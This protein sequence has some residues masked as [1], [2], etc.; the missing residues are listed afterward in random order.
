MIGRKQLPSALLGIALEGT[1]VHVVQVRRAAESIE[2]QNSFSFDL[3]GNPTT[4]DPAVIGQEIRTALEQKNIKEHRCVIT[5]P[6]HWVLSLQTRIPEIPEGDIADFLALEAER[7]FAYDPA[8]LF[9]SAS[10]CRLPSG[11]QFAILGGVQRPQIENLQHALKIA[12]LKALS[13]TLGISAIHQAFDST[14]SPLLLLNLGE[15]SVELAITY[16]AELLTLRSLEN[17]IIEENGHGRSVQSDVIGRE[18]RVT[19]GQLPPEIRAG[20]TQV[21]IFGSAEQVSLLRTELASRFQALGLAIDAKL[22]TGPLAQALLTEPRPSVAALA[23]AAASLSG[24]KAAFEFLPPK[25]SVWKQF[26]ART[27][28]RKLAW[29]AGIVGAV[30]LIFLAAFLVQ[31]WQLSQLESRWSGMAPRVTELEAMQQQIKR[32]RPWFNNSF[33]SL[34]ILKKVTEAFPVDGVVTAKTLEVRNESQVICSGVARDNQALFKM[35]DQLR[36]TK[37]VAD[38][39]MDQIRGKSPL[40]FSFNFR[41]AEGGSGEH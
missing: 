22:Q 39:K 7:N 38:V 36:S 12:R 26:T 8:S 13:Y 16:G 31:G 28:S 25:T 35:L 1:R 29:A 30:V 15:R 6:L 10:R 4:T 24:R 21:R 40:Q 32:F 20:L 19:L 11:E 9:I 14:P 2:L 5:L 23:G 18:L 17:A 37:E 3:S 27:S 34:T 33:R 41:W